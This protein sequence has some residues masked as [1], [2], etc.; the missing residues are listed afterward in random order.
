MKVLATQL[1][2]GAVAAA[3]S[4]PFQQVLQPPQEAAERWTRPLHNLPEP[5]AAL[6]DDARAAWEEVALIFPEAM[7][8]A[9]FVSSPKKHTRRP[10]R[11]WDHITKGADIQSVWVQNEDGEKERDIEGKLEPYNLRTKKVDP[12]SLGVDP[13]V[14]QYSGYLDDEENDKHLF[15]C[16][17]RWCPKASCPSLILCNR[18]FRIPQRPRK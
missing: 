8:K 11:H 7:D 6:N 1:L 9:S 15:Y 4:P 3:W 13:G 5:L 17:F 2:F 12:S 18:V 10:N 14:K 16:K